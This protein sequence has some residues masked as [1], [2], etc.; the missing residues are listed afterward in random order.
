MES[1]IGFVTVG[2]FPVFAANLWNSLP[3]QLTSWP[4]L[5]IFRQRLKTFLFQR[6][7]HDLIIWHLIVQLAVICH[8]DHTNNFDDDDDDENTWP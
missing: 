8:L 4:S 1:L 3:A 7:Y 6:S 5:T 2:S